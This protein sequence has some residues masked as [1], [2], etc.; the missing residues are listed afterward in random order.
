MSV[1]TEEQA[2]KFLAPLRRNLTILFLHE[3]QAKARVSHFLLRCASSHSLTTVVLDTDAF[4]CTNMDRLV[5]GSQPIRGEVFL[6]PVTG[7]EIDS[8]VVLLSSKI[9]LLIIDDLNTLY[10]L[11]SDTAKSQQL[12]ILMKLLSHNAK[13]NKTWV[14]AT[15][16][17]TDFEENQGASRRS[18]TVLGDL[19][20]DTEVSAGSMKLKADLRDW[21]N[22]QFVL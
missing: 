11:A 21:A 9:D 18:L 16:F 13:M 7:F 3:I 15:A 4:Y 20:V 6:P 14:I 5:D 17:K 8:L 1:P 22:G 19:L 10:S 2:S 12:T